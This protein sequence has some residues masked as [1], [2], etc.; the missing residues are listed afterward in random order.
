MLKPKL[1]AGRKNV[2]LALGILVSSVAIVSTMPA[3]AASSVILQ[4]SAIRGDSQVRGF[5]GGID[6]LSFMQT[7]SVQV[8]QFAGSGM[9]GKPVCGQIAVTKH[10]DTASTP[11]LVTMLTGQH[12]PLVTL[13]VLATGG[14]NTQYPIY[15]IKMTNVLLSSITQSE[16]SDGIAE[17]VTM[18]AQAYTYTYV[19]LLPNGAS[20]IPITAG[21]DCVK[22]LK[23]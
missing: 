15:T 14:G 23:L 6:L 1:I 13:T 11:M 9:A 22:N 4:T 19:P 16:S 21:F 7:S 2:R 20:G 17:S 8:N 3:Q 12:L 10:L 5:A 18:T